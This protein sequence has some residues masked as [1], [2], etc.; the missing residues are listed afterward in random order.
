M[1]DTGRGEER[2]AR[3]TRQRHNL[4]IRPCKISCSNKV[5]LSEVTKFFVGRDYSL[6]LRLLIFSGTNIVNSVF[7][8]S[9]SVH[10]HAYGFCLQ[11]SETLGEE[12]RA[13]DTRRVIRDTICSCQGHDLL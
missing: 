10:I 1:R 6:I 12:S 7:R 5:H 9:G 11:G 2:R 8:T 3:D 4:F 13:R